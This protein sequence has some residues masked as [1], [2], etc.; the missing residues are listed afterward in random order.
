MGQAP[1][2]PGDLDL[3]F[4]PR[5]FCL[6]HPP[7]TTSKKSSAA[8]ST[9]QNIIQKEVDLNNIIP[10]DSDPIKAIGE[11]HQPTTSTE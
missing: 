4:I 9:N 3:L 11:D 10:P 7:Q 6:N 5:G 1:S 8:K 2:V